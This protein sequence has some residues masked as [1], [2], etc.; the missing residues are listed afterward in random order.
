MKR[1]CLPLRGREF[2]DKFQPTVQG[3][4]HTHFWENGYIWTGAKTVSLEL[5]SLGFVL[6]L[7]RYV[8]LI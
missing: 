6:S 2:N 8:L 1:V 3:I 4:T 7:T 5:C